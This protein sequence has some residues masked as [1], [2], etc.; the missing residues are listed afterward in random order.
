MET[1]TAE[2][3]KKRYG[4]IAASQFEPNK[5]EQSLFSSIKNDLANRGQQNVAIMDSPGTDVFSNIAKGTEIAANSAGGV[6][7]VAGDAASHLPVVGPLIGGASSA[8]GNFVG[9][10]FKALTNGLSN[11]KFFKEAAAGLPENSNLDKGL[12]VASGGGQIAGDILAADQG[13]GLANKTV[14]LAKKAG[15]AIANGLPELPS[16]GLSKA[17]IGSAMT[18]IG[19]SLPKPIAEVLGTKQSWIDHNLAMALDLT[20]TDLNNIKLSTGNEVGS[21]LSNFNLIGENK[22]TTLGMVK[23]FF[24]ENYNA[25]R[26]EIGKVDTVYKP[27]QIPGYTDVLKRLAAETQDKLGLEGV[28]KTVQELLNKTDITLSDVQ[29]VKE[30]FDNYYKV[31]NAIGE[32]GGGMIKQGLAKTRAQIQQFIESEVKDATGA[33]IRNM[34]NNVST[35]RSVADAIE[36]RSQAGL[37]RA[38]FTWRDAAIGMGLTYFGSPIVGLAAVAVRKV[39][40]SPSVRLRFARFLDGLS[41]AQR[42]Q[43]SEE[44]KTGKLSKEVKNTL[45]LNDSEMQPDIQM[46]PGPNPKPDSGLPTIKY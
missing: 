28:N 34:N 44:F 42:A 27:S 4:G 2:E 18:S 22:A 11:T 7:D 17:G 38:Q 32:T 35:A 45:Q 46:G 30:L 26:S 40:T 21:W 16:E 37:T 12:R 36:T 29:Q 14:G 39:L 20:R 31:Y 3:F 1:L 19:N 41:D 23:N 13:A 6:L 15:S 9:S 24:T 33:D 25:V 5:Q 43:I 10:G 8:I